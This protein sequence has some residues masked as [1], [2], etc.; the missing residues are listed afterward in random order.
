MTIDVGKAI[1]EAKLNRFHIAIA[2]LGFLFT[3]A[4]GVEMAS[5]G[6]ITTEIAKDWNISPEDLM[7]AHLAVLV[8]ILIGSLLAGI[9]SD[10]IGRRKSL[11]FMFIFA[12]VGMGISFFIQNM[13]QLVT[14]RFLTGF[15]AGG[16]LPIAIALVAEYVPI[17]YRNMLVVF[18]F[19]GASFASFVCGYLGNYFIASYGWRGMFLMGFLL[20]MP[21]FLWMLF[22]LPESAKYLVV[23]N[24]NA[25]QA[26]TLLQ[27]ANPSVSIAAEDQLIINEP[28]QT[29]SSL[30]TL[31]S[32]G[33]AV[34]T[35]LLWIAFIAGQ[36][37]VFLM[38][39]WLPTFL[40]NAGWEAGLSRQGVGLYYLGGGIGAIILGYLADRLGAAKVL[41]ATFPIAAVLYF[42]LGQNI[43]NINIWWII[44]P[45]AGAF[46]IG[47]I[48][49]LA[50]FAAD[51]Y[52]TSVR[53]TGVGAALGV[54]RIGSILTPPL[55]KFLLASGVGIIGFFNVAMIAPIVASISIWLLV[56]FKRRNNKIN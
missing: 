55:G 46:A 15:G 49:A 14:L 50:P 8:G 10:K 40:E 37:I 54:G 5:L 53:G 21:I 43:N 38:S 39:I 33:M 27:K 47:G 11:L 17:K 42:L 12:T 2:A 48:M 24:K 16:A 18:A 30:A 26:K 52:P 36:V 4:E 6:F 34:T 7:L 13:T 32:S 45:F 29:K 22:W 1:D 20:A 44:A 51:L 3:V 35:L 41:I 31:F 25:D 23:N 28:P 19:S 56:L 9:L